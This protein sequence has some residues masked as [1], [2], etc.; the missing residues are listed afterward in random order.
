M[1]PA[2]LPLGLLLL[3][4]LTAAPGGLST[5]SATQDGPATVG[6]EGPSA[7]VT[8][9]V[10]GEIAVEA[11]EVVAPTPVAGSAEAPRQDETSQDAPTEEVV[12]AFEAPDNRSCEAHYTIE[13]K[14]LDAP[15]S[16][17]QR[18]LSGKLRLVWIN[19]TEDPVK[20]LWFHL[21][22]NA[23]ANNRSVHLT[24]AEG[25]LRGVKV[26]RG[27]GYQQVTG[28]RAMG[29]DLLP[30]LEFVASDGEQYAEDRT[31]FRVDL[32]TAVP[33]GGRVEVNLE[34][35]SLIPRVRRRTG[36]HEDFLLMSHWFPKLGVY[37]GG[38]G[39][40]CHQFHMNTEFYA[41]YGTYDVTLDLPSKYYQ[42]GEQGR[43]TLKVAASGVQVGGVVEDPKADRIRV[44]FLA[45]SEEDRERLDPLAKGARI[46]R[47]QVHGFAWSADP[48]FV[49]RTFEFDPGS[50]RSRY[51]QY[52]VD[53]L[54]AVNANPDW[55][56]AEDFALRP[57]TVRVF[58]QPEH[59]DQ[60]ERHANATMAALFLYGLWWGDY[61][62]AEVSVIDPAWGASAAGGMEYPTLFT[63]GTSMFTEP[64]MHRPESVTVHEAGHQFWYGLVGNNE[65]EAAWLD[66]GFNSY[67]DSEVLMRQYGPQRTSTR[68]AGLPVWGKRPSGLPD[69]GNFG[70]ILTG[71]SWKVPTRSTRLQP[72]ASSAFLD[73]WRDQPFLTFAPEW[74]DPVRGDRAGYLRDPDT[75]PIETWAFHY[76]D[77]NSYRT[78]SYPRTAASLRTLRDLVG[79]TLFLRGMR[80]YSEQWRYRHPYPEDFYAAFQAGSGE[81]VGWFFQDV[82]QGTKTADWSVGVRQP[83]VPGPQGLFPLP[84]GSW[85]PPPKEGEAGA[86]SQGGEVA[87][88][89]TVRRDGDLVLPVRIEVQFEPVEGEESRSVSFT[90][91]REQQL[92]QT[93]WRLP[94]VPGKAK[95]R[96]VVLDPKPIVHLDTDLSNNAWYARAD[97]LA[98][99]R[100]AERSI[101][102]HS[103]ILQWLSRVAG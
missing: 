6:A 80:H 44:R 4:P 19:H 83:Q 18:R 2:L 8:E 81:D 68:Y 56:T 35:E 21:H 89:V 77:R 7:E 33:K 85:G 5:P 57:V 22:H 79:S 91:T 78:N 47:P 46:P 67:T 39:W 34:W 9:E 99:W 84:D 30:S 58:V 73:F 100:W 41:D 12:R 17:S 26:D 86:P 65:Y 94:L 97:R 71:R 32:P 102:W 64:A 20:D 24:E 75:D 31:V 43:G 66:E 62:Y 61:P 74:T 50:W 63:C 37:E 15:E 72:L 16:A 52:E 87:Y 82:F 60:I 48:D 10:T 36:H 40:N 103:R 76:C 70:G 45:P 95:I 59:D 55:D 54:D 49:V 38:R 53:I 101:T 88:D 28:I 42:R 92:A 96:S 1:D 13:A 14:L 29:A 93:W 98:P 27:W 25:R 90:W 23:Y 51:P 69:G 3:A 11:T